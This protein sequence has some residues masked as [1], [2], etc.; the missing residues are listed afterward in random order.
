[1][2]VR[3]RGRKGTRQVR[4]GD[5]GD[6]RSPQKSTECSE[7]G[8]N[9]GARGEFEEGAR[10]CRPPSRKQGLC[11]RSCPR[12]RVVSFAAGRAD[13]RACR[14]RRQSGPA[15]AFQ[16]TLRDDK[17]KPGTHLHRGRNLCTAGLDP[18][19]GTRCWS[20][21]RPRTSR[22]RRGNPGASGGSPATPSTHLCPSN[23]SPP[24]SR[25]PGPGARV[26]ATDTFFHARR[27]HALATS[28]LRPRLASSGSCGED[29][30]STL[31]HDR[32]ER[33]CRAR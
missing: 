14:V 32:H 13:A 26:V 27:L 10:V 19:P 11:T 29:S 23:T 31:M 8:I 1:M 18:Q 4:R 9:R 24:R 21:P 3:E 16:K 22:A 30:A 20:R 7:R 2:D 6:K 25:L 12:A 5:V 15:G 28:R 33:A 17:K